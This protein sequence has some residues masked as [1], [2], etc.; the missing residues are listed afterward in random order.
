VKNVY[1]LRSC[2]L[3]PYLTRGTTYTRYW[4]NFMNTMQKTLGLVVKSP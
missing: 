4:N 2:V 3:T 1:V